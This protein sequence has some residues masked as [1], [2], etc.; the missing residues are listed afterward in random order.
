[1]K[2]GRSLLDKGMLEAKIGVLTRIVTVENLTMRSPL[3]GDVLAAVEARD[4][5]LAQR[6]A[7]D[8][9]RNAISLTRI[10]IPNTVEEKECIRFF[11]TV[12]W[13][14]HA[15]VILKAAEQHTGRWNLLRPFLR[16]RAASVAEECYRLRAELRKQL[17]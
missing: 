10:T 9:R 13:W 2:H 1:M 14:A 17:L 7:F 12:Y 11:H 15:L 16:W 6:L 4:F 8:A 5:E 3:V